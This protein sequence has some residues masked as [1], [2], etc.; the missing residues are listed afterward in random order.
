[1]LLCS[2]RLYGIAIT[3]ARK[4]RGLK[5]T[6]ALLEAALVQLQVVRHRD[7]LVVSYGPGVSMAG[8]RA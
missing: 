8:H 5:G 7:H 1:M 4:G 6:T 3:C 2:S